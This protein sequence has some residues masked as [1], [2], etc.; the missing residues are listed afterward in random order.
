M[1]INSTNGANLNP[2]V[3]HLNKQSI[4]NS[5][6]QKKDQLEISAQAKELQKGNPFV[7]AR[8]QKVSEL[9]EQ[10]QKGEYDVDAKKTSEKMID[11]WVNRRI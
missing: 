8:Q 6:M 11:F 9:K 10:I 1:K 3:N 2:Y 7:E 5:G 4:K